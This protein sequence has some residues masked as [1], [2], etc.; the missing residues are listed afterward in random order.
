MD[1]VIEPYSQQHGA[2]VEDTIRNGR[3]VRKRGVAQSQRVESAVDW[4]GHRGRG[5]A[6]GDAGAVV[7]PIASRSGGAHERELELAGAIEIGPA[8]DNP[9]LV[10]DDLRYLRAKAWD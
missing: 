10:V 1:A 6:A 9:S 5:F 7:A 3:H 8:D 2:I 4:Q